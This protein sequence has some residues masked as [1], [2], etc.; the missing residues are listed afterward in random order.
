MSD[1]VFEVPPI[2]F[3]KECLRQAE[4]MAKDRLDAIGK[5]KDR[6]I[7]LMGWAIAVM[8]ACVAYGSTHPG[9]WDSVCVIL[10]GGSY[11][12]FLCMRVIRPVEIKPTWFSSTDLD[13][14]REDH[15]IQSEEHL[16]YAMSYKIEDQVVFNVEQHKS[17][18]QSLRH[19]RAYCLVTAVAAS[20]AFLFG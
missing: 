9:K 3:T 18:Q 2:W 13:A 11:V 19:A 5:T 20:I 6:A 16:Q 8:S 7:S 17:L 14:L 12:S 4:A 15:A 1:E 10:L